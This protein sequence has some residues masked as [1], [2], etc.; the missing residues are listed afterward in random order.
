MRI[1]ILSDIHDNIWALADALT[2]LQGCEALLVLGDLCAPFTITAIAEGFAGP[3]HVVWGNNDGDK[4]L[5]TR[6]ADRADNVTLHGD[7]ATLQIGGRS[8]LI[9]HYAEVARPIAAAGMHDLVC[10]GHSHR[11]SIEQV[12]RTVL[13]NPG[14]VMGRFGVHSVGVYDTSTGQAEILE[15]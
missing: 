14:E 10:F 2:R 4:L 15:F 12:G 8:I 5:I 3:V 11:R 13:L 9:T 7:I 6:N 1:G